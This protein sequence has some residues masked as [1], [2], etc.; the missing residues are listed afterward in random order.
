MKE[1]ASKLA[2][3]QT[4]NTKTDEEK[5]DTLGKFSLSANFNYRKFF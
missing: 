4:N 5:D 3:M 1:S 2:E